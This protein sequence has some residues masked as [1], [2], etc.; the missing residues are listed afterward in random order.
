MMEVLNVM[1]VAAKQERYSPHKS[2]H[3]SKTKGQKTPNK[4]AG[5]PKTGDQTSS[6]RT[7]AE[8]NKSHKTTRYVLAV[9]LKNNSKLVRYRFFSGHQSGSS[10]R[11]QDLNP[12]I[13]T[14]KPSQ[15]DELESFQCR[16][17]KTI[18]EQP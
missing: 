10:Y 18:I 14:R 5:R 2:S 3:S 15:W 7:A 4:P 13:H 6:K 16:S 17:D 11:I 9:K 1:S 12:F 8:T